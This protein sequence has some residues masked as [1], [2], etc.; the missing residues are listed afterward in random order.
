[1]SK[2]KC[3]VC[4]KI[5][6]YAGQCPN[7]KKKKGGTAATAEEIDF[8][9]QFQRECAF[10][11][12]C[13]SVETTPSIWY[14]DSGALSHMTGLREHF[15]DLKDTEV[16]IEISLGDARVVRVAGVG[17]VAFQRDGMPP[18]SFTDVLYVPGMKNNLISVSTL[19]DRGLQVTSRGTEVLI[20]PQGSSLASGQL[21]GVRDGKLFR[22]LFHPL[23][24]LVASSDSSK[25]ICEL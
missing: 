13:T 17:T 24:A 16:R 23:H 25:Q 8:Q 4:K 6:H 1:M 2:V 19:Q 21:I 11:V 14:I 3:F 12:C 18:I 15:S 9:T 20:H 22:L 5:G 10:L 7:R